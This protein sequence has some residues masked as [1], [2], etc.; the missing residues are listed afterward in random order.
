[1]RLWPAV[2]LVASQLGAQQP[3][4]MGLVH[5]S[6]LQVDTTR[7]PGELKIRT[8][9]NHVYHFLFD[10]KTY[11]ERDEEL[12]SAAGLLKGDWVEIVSDQWPGGTERY[13]RT[14]QV[15]GKKAAGRVPPS[16]ARLRAYRALLH[17]HPRGDLTFSGV[18]A[19][20]NGERLVLHTHDGEIALLLRQ[21]TR[22]ISQGHLVDP[23][24]LSPNTRV[25]VRA[26]R[27]ASGEMEVYQVVWG[28]ILEPR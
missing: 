1:M 16:V 17:A 21:D 2:L 7:S 11:F 10:G 5:G 15:V 20:L 23:A 12:T 22:Y 9:D 26:G 6:L 27:N 14:V 25:F 24:A 19:R 8:A 4:P 13:A 28:E 3:A 18:V